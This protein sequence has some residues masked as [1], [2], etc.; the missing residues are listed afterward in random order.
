MGCN[1]LLPV[2]GA[3][4]KRKDAISQ[5]QVTPARSL[6]SDGAEQLPTKL[7]ARAE[8]AHIAVAVQEDRPRNIVAA[9]QA[10]DRI[11]PGLGAIGGK[12][13]LPKVGPED[14]LTVELIDSSAG[15]KI[16]VGRLDRKSVV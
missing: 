7:R 12:T 4:L 16:E 3:I 13:C 11:G 9:A 2:S 6:D 5:L 1:L 15:E 10:N 8:A 14:D